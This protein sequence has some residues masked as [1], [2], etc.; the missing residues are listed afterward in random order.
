[1][2]SHLSHNTI[3]P[4]SNALSVRYYS[5]HVVQNLSFAIFATFIA[6]IHR[7]PHSGSTIPEV[8]SPELID[9][10]PADFGWK[11][12]TQSGPPQPSVT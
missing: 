11:W 8:C 5:L 3:S 10:R 12:E 1:M 9:G 2:R 7:Y 4:T 6:R